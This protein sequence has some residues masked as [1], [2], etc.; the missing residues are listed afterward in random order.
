[1]VLG[2]HPMFRD[3][4]VV[5]GTHLMFRA[6]NA[7]N[8]GPMSFL[9]HS[10]SRLPHSRNINMTII[11]RWQNQAE[12]T[13]HLHSQL[14]SRHHSSRPILYVL[15]SFQQNN[16]CKLLYEQYFIYFYIF[17]SGAI[18]NIQSRLNIHRHNF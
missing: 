1:M 5:M 2:T 4:E 14:F 9:L 10:S 17:F 16:F 3:S 6:C 15:E 12:D 11:C 13:I 7:T 18:L 8:A